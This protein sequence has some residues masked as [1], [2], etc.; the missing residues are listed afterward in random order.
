MQDV[1][2]VDAIAHDSVDDD[3]IGMNDYFTRAGHS[4]ASIEIRVDGGG[5]GC[6]FDQIF[7][8]WRGSR[9]TFSDVPDYLQEVEARGLSPYDLQRQAALD[10]WRFSAS[11]MISSISAIT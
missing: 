5:F 3:V 6:C 1:E 4:A 10:L 8:C 2:H 7:E 11:E 9:A